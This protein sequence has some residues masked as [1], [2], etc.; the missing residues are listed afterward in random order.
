MGMTKEEKIRGLYNLKEYLVKNPIELDRHK[1]L[2]ITLIDYAI[3]SLE[4]QPCEDCIS[5]QAVNDMLSEEWNKYMPMELDINLSFVMEKI[6]ELPFVAP[7]V[8]WI[9]VSERLPE[10][11]ESVLCHCQA[12]IYEV[13]KLTVDGWYY[14]PTH[15]Y[16][17]SFVIAWMPLPELYKEARE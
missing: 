7:K 9:P 13:L 3:E 15:C 17:E 12:N 16:M 10:L 8:R 6:N 4:Q 1:S 14:N 11:G 5:R 2:P